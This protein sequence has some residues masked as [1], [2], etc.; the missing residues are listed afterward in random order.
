MR[1]RSE[2]EEG[3]RCYARQLRRQATPKACQKDGD[4]GERFFCGST[5]YVTIFMAKT[6]GTFRGGEVLPWEVAG[7][8][9]GI[10][11]SLL[12]PS[13]ATLLYRPLG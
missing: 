6:S 10:M 1:N 2:A 5:E 12:P 7:W 13:D 3:G 4:E 8:L 11:Y 9:V